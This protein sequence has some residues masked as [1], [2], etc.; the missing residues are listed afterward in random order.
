MSEMELVKSDP[1]NQFKKG[2]PKRV[3]FLNCPS[4]LVSKFL[5]SKNEKQRQCP[6]RSEDMRFCLK[7]LE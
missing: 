6:K 4:A 7:F 1:R 2:T 5:R 3:P